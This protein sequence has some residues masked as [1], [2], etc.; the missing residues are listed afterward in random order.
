MTVSTT[1]FDRPVP[2]FR[3]FSKMAGKARV[4]V[5]TKMLIPLEV[6]M[7]GAARNLNSTDFFINMLIMRERDTAIVSRC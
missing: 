4:A 1:R 2:I 6:A 5:D 7:A 3:V